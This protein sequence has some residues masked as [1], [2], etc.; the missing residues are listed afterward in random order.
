M[1]SWGRGT[2]SLKHWNALLP[3]KLLSALSVRQCLSDPERPAIFGVD[4]TIL[5]SPPKMKTWQLICV[6]CVN[7]RPISGIAYQREK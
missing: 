6:I 5:G 3:L 4:H 7:L 2:G 1:V